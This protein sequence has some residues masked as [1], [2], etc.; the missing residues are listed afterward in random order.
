MWVPRLMPIYVVLWCCS[1][2][3]HHSWYNFV[4]FLFR[5]MC[6]SF[7]GSSHVLVTVVMKCIDKQTQTHPSCCKKTIPPK[8][9]YREFCGLRDKQK[10]WL[11]RGAIFDK[12]LQQ[13]DLLIYVLR[14][15][16][17]VGGYTL[18]QRCRSCLA[19]GFVLFFMSL[20]NKTLRLHVF[21]KRG[22]KLE[23]TIRI[24]GKIGIL[25]PNSFGLGTL[26]APHG[27]PRV[28]PWPCAP[29]VKHKNSR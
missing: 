13:I 20:Y 7:S 23:P 26:I 8:Q 19:G 10:P 9:Q 5:A 11:F 27:P 2:A 29:S 4:C 1:E 18:G 28:I 21:W 15:L 17:G 24:I 3:A 6:M 16:G 14:K 12:V 25:D 22:P